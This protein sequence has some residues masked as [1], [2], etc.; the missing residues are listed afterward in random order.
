MALY[1]RG[2]S[3]DFW[4]Q[5]YQ[6]RGI[7]GSSLTPGQTRSLVNPILESDYATTLAL[8]DRADR[9]DR[10]NQEM[11]LR[12]QQ[13][14]KADRAA[15]A[16]G[17]FQ[18]VGA[19]VNLGIA[20]KYLGLVNPAPG[21]APGA[22]DY[23]LSAIQPLTPPPTQLTGSLVGGAGSGG[24]PVIGGAGGGGLAPGAPGPADKRAGGQGHRGL[25]PGHFPVHP[26][27]NFG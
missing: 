15:R 20:D 21:L 17:A 9:R 18:T 4:R 7:T 23:G 1:R 27:G 16:S 3:S 25:E 10:F 22:T 11:D 12:K 14:E 8:Q 24:A 19:G 5:Y 6:R 13:I 2:A 26:G